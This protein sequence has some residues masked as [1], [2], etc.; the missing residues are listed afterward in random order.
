MAQALI[1]RGPPPS[2][3]RKP[4][5]GPIPLTLFA[6]GPFPRPGPDRRAFSDGSP[7]ASSDHRVR[8]DF[9]VW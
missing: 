1:Q 2:V 7:L 3:P 9:G 5:L 4:S 6:S 8:T